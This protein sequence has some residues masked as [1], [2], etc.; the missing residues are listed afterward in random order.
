M[1]FSKLPLSEQEKVQQNE[2]DLTHC[3][4]CLCPI[5]D[6]KSL[7]CL[8][9]FCLRCL[10]EW[11]KEHTDKVDCPVCKDNFTVPKGGVAEFKSNFYITRLLERKA[12]REK[13]Q[14]RSVECMLCKKSNTVKV[15]ARCH[16][17]KEYLCSECVKTHQTDE[18]LR[19]HKVNLLE[20]SGS[21]DVSLQD[22]FRKE[23]CS[24]HDG[25]ELSFFCETCSILICHDCSVL[26]HPSSTHK[27]VYVE[28]ISGAQG[29]KLKELSSRCTSV[30]KSVTVAMK[31]MD[32]IETDLNAAI[33]A[34][35]TELADAT[36]QIEQDFLTKLKQKQQT[37][38]DKINEI[39]KKHKSQIKFDRDSL[40]TRHLQLERALDMTAHITNTGSPYDLAS[41]YTTFSHRLETLGDIKPLTVASSLNDV[42]FYANKQASVDVPSLG[43]VVDFKTDLTSEWVEVGQ[44]CKNVGLSEAQKIALY[45]SGDFAIANYWSGKVKIFDSAG[46]LKNNMETKQ[47]SDTAY[48]WPFSVV[49]WSGRGSNSVTYIT[50][51]N[52]E[53]KVFDSAAKLINKFRTYPPGKTKNPSTDSTLYGLALNFRENLIV[54]DSVRKCISIHSLSGDHMNSFKVSIRPFYIS[55]A[56]TEDTIIISECD[57]QCAQITNSTGQVFH[58]LDASPVPQVA[59]YPTGSWFN[60]DK[61]FIIASKSDSTKPGGIFQ[62]SSNGQYLRCITKEVTRPADVA[63]DEEGKLLV[64]E[65]TYVRVF[66]KKC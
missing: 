14:E 9:L 10:E 16:D 56:P 12:L 30:A 37:C 44:I 33:E 27:L 2:T 36:S 65:Q 21:G 24:K 32:D 7:P 51:T 55:A 25:Q 1:A 57:S 26:E 28:D 61:E 45:P 18:A 4:I 58:T 19:N 17:C 39:G 42:K 5:Q 60:G 52:P 6:P 31:A 66:K 11:V 15:T 34:A 8:H 62:F 64:L 46:N 54:G 29:K 35:K 38:L 20:E 47:D 41:I 53:V 40:Q 48:S 59:W 43:M 3:G 50:D 22:K 63:I 13:I 49:I 23:Y